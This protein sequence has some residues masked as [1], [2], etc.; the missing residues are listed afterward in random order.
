MPFERT[1][2]ANPGQPDQPHWGRIGRLALAA[3]AAATLSACA[4]FSGISFSA[5][6][7]DP[8]TLGLHREAAVSAPADPAEAAWWTR[9]QDAQLDRLVAQALANSPSLRVAQTRL[10]RMQATQDLVAAAD[11][12]KVNA[13]LNATH[14]LYTANGMIPPPVAGHIYDSATLQASSSWELDFFGKNAAALE[15]TVGQV[16]AAQADT[17]AAR[18]LLALNV[19]RSYF[20]LLRL[21]AQ[22]GVAHKALALREQTRAL[23][24]DRVQA[25]LDTQL[26]LQQA[27]S[28]LP[29][30][31]LQIAQLQEQKALVLNALA[32]LTAQPVSGLALDLGPLPALPD[33]AQ[34]QAV[35][36]DLLGRRM[37]ITAARWRIEAAVKDV[38]AAK[39]Q[40]YPNINLTAFAGLSSLGFD[41]LFK[42]GSD[43][44]GVGP[45]IRLPLFD[46]GRL[47]AN[48]RSKTVDVDAA[49]E[50]Y[51]AQV[52]EAV[53]EV[54]DRLASGQAIVQQQQEQAA[55]QAA[56][57]AALE[58]ALARY[59]AGL[60]NFLQVLSAEAP[61]LAQ[62]RL[63]VDLSARALDTRV[64]L[65]HAVGGSAPQA[66]TA[67]AAAS[68][69]NNPSMTK[70]TP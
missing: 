43:Q 68:T 52:F 2:L 24:H 35:P 23:V 37:D 30:A 34:L 18:Q 20:S 31:R 41:K 11:G 16:H 8:A 21:Q 19:T 32:A 53:H 63:A 13:D 61:V 60:G 25:G 47:R 46:G 50:A 6:P 49:I 59:Q 54:A 67:T 1:P 5:K 29:D 7:V 70:T 65:L 4:S 15:A 69:P 55:T 12:P 38:D 57:E 44:W 28:A 56:S 33:G 10:A 64:Q 36:L 62:R 40:F 39:A 17:L 42:S 9:F 3:T 48:L 27:E 22:L 14:Q 26:E 51:N 58:I 66:G 45:A